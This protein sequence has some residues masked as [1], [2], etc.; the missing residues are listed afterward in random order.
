LTPY[1]ARRALEH[2]RNPATTD[3]LFENYKLTDN[4]AQQRGL[5][6]I[7]HDRYNP[8]LNKVRPISLKNPRLKE[9]LDAAKDL[10]NG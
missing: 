2:K 8:P 5:E 7:L 10:E 3:F 6:Q 1:I 4:Y 9:Y